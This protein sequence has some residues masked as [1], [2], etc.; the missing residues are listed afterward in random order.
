[1]DNG[2]TLRADRVPHY[3]HKRNGLQLVVAAAQSCHRSAAGLFKKIEDIRR[4]ETSVSDEEFSTFLLMK[5]LRNSKHR[6][7]YFFNPVEYED[8]RLGT[9]KCIVLRIANKYCK[10]PHEMY[11]NN[12]NNN[13]NV[14][15]LCGFSPRANYNHQATAAC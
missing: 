14:I 13:N 9:Y 2:R 5:R 15:K 8:T 4:S 6:I 3:G 7:Q 11:N 1:M 10:D 12:N